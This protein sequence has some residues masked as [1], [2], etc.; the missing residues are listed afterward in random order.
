MLGPTHGANDVVGVLPREPVAMAGA[1]EVELIA[2]P[3]PTDLLQEVVPKALRF[4]YLE[5]P[6]TRMSQIVVVTWERALQLI[7]LQR[8]R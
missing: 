2:E 4:G 7:A 6:D 8:R 1:V 5:D 3:G